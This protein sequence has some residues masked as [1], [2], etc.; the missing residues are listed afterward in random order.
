[1][2]TL[3]IRAYE[4]TVNKLKDIAEA[5]NLSSMAEVIDYLVDE[6][7]NGVVEIGGSSGSTKAHIGGSSGST[8]AHIGVNTV[9]TSGSQQTRAELVA[10][11]EIEYE[12][13][14]NE[15]KIEIRRQDYIGA[16]YDEQVE[17]AEDLKELGGVVP[18]TM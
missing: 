4:N 17:I 11:G 14:T 8:K 5:N 15:E 16:S 18:V 6:E 3:K 13:C 9:N 2:K 7:L 10:S 1:M 12:D